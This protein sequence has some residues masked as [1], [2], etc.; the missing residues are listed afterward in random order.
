MSNNPA[1]N[2]PQIPH[3][4]IEFKIIKDPPPYIPENNPISSVREEPVK[5]TTE[6]PTDSKEL[7]HIQIESL[8]DSGNKAHQTLSRASSNQSLGINPQLIGK[9]N[10]PNAGIGSFQKG[11][12]TPQQLPLSKRSCNCKHSKCLKLYC[13]CFSSGEYCKNCNCMC[14]NNNKD[15]E[16]VRRESVALILERNPNAFRPKISN[17]TRV[18]ETFSG[19]DINSGK[20]SKVSI[21][22]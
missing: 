6:E 8:L 1:P 7:I 3:F 20:H 13:E 11:V 2:A 19:A 18:H 9:G 22:N 4:P 17:P 21:G 14:C 16:L 10:N 5:E 15:N 12:V